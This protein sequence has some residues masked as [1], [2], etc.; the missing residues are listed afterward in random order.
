MFN[1]V[2]LPPTEAF[3]AMRVNLQDTKAR[4]NELALENMSLKRELEE[5]KLKRDQ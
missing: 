3:D 2:S 1:D 4:R 5:A